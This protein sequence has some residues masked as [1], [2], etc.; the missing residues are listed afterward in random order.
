MYLTNLIIAFK[1]MC[2]NNIFVSLLK[3]FFLLREMYEIMYSN[4]NNNIV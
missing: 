1:K 4:V 3:N 2:L